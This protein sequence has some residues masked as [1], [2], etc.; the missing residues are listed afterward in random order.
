MRCIEKIST[1]YVAGREDSYRRRKILERA[2]LNGARVR[3]QQHV[4]R[5]VERIVHVH[6]R[7]VARKIQRAEVVPFRLCF[8]TEGD[9]ES[10]L[11]ENVL[12]LFDDES[13][14]MSSAFPS[15]AGRQ[16]EVG[17]SR[18]VGGARERRCLRQQ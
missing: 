13:D 1:V 14:R 12:S 3:A 8:G 6:R 11:A 10:D 18:P 4:V 7:M 15:P 9:S 5:Q 2:N 17:M 16:R